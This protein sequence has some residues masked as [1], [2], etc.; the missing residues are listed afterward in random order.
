MAD[1]GTANPEAGAVVSSDVDAIG[2]VSAML[3]EPSQG[4]TE[5]PA[6]ETPQEA[7]EAPETA[8]DAPQEAS[9]AQDTDSPSEDAAEAEPDGGDET[10]PDTLEGFAAELGMEAADLAG[11][12]RVPIT[13]DGKV[14]HVTIA[15]AMKGHQLQADYTRKTQELAEERKGLEAQNQQAQEHFAARFQRVD[16]LISALEQQ[17]AQGPSEADLNVLL[18]TDPQEYLRA[19]ARQ[20]ARRKATEAATAERDQHRNE[21]TQQGQ[22]RA[23]QH[24]QE[25]QGRLLQVIPELSDNTKATAFQAGLTEH[26]MASSF[27][28]EEADA[29]FSGPFDH[30]QVLLIRDAKRY[31][32]QQQ[33]KPK[34][35][36]KL[37]DLPRV[38][39][40]GAPRTS[41]RAEDNRGD[42][43]KRMHRARNTGNK[44]AGDAAAIDLVKGML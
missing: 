27:T 26:L 14:Q 12:L 42:A 25:Q 36:K 40:P 32:D 31:R 7:E 19:T 39:K 23:A 6:Q 37:K 18:E 20:E 13:V 38:Q 41:T 3:S 43:L 16:N 34:L 11:H 5:A 9:E 17:T 29:F 15:E 33:A 35:T 2:M 4:P 28:Q 22:Y 44:G 21:L 30:R 1:A 24:R 10:L 8:P